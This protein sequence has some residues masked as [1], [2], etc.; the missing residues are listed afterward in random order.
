MNAPVLTAIEEF[1]LVKRPAPVLNIERLV[2]CTHDQALW[3]NRQA[4]RQNYKSCPTIAI[5]L[6][7][8]FCRWHSISCSRIVRIWVNQLRL[9]TDSAA[10]FIT[11]V[12]PDFP[13]PFPP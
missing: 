12:Y 11:I 9:I 8:E 7:L 3:L 6:H 5:T 2:T 1:E 4:S 13:D 10:L